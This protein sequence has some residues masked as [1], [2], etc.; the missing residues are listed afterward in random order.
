MC[1][2]SNKPSFIGAML[3]MKCPNC[4]KGQ[5]FAHKSIFP[6]NKCLKLVDHCSICGHKMV[7]ENNNGPGISYALTVIIFFLN[8][9]WYD[10]IFGIRYDDDSLYYFLVASTVVVLL[11]QPWIMRYSR[12]LYLYM[13]V[14]YQSNRHLHKGQ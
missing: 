8:L 2:G 14:P 5:A 13:T 10:P 3:S 9:L 4:R 11:L 6:L 1:A 7:Q 12:I